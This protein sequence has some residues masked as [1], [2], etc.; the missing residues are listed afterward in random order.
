MAEP[1]N[2]RAVRRNAARKLQPPSPVEIRKEGLREEEIRDHDEQRGVRGCAV[3]WRSCSTESGDLRH[4]AHHSDESAGRHLHNTH[5]PYTGRAGHHGPTGLA[6]RQHSNQHANL[7]ALRPRHGSRLDRWGCWQWEHRSWNGRHRHGQWLKRRSGWRD[8]FG[9]G[10]FIDRN[11]RSDVAHGDDKQFDRNN[12][13]VERRGQYRDRDWSTVSGRHAGGVGN[14]V[15]RGIRSNVPRFRT[16][17]HRCGY[18][19]G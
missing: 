19:N 18:R 3:S 15:D 2:A 12:H 16:E 6:H 11:R 9:P 5:A 14:R 8:Q 1:T 7:D 13:L 4:V 10:G 17:Q